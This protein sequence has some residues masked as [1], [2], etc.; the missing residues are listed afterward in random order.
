MTT[1]GDLQASRRGWVEAKEM[2]TGP[3]RRRLKRPPASFLLALFRRSMQPVKD[4]E[5]NYSSNFVQAASAG[6]TMRAGLRL[7]RRPRS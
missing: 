6:E 1:F 4:E 3:V 5:V 7:F 2:E